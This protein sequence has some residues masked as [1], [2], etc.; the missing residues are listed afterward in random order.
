M[1]TVTIDSIESHSLDIVTITPTR[2]D[3][4]RPSLGLVCPHC[5]SGDEDLVM[6]PNDL[7]TITCLNCGESYSPREARD[8][9]AEQLAPWDRFLAFIASSPR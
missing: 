5:W 3:E 9:I 8:T 4:P 1:A 2:H 7:R 6:D